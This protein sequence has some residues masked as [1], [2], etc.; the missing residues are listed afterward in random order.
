MAAYGEKRKVVYFNLDQPVQRQLWDFAGNI[1][2]GKE[3]K[4]FLGMRMRGFTLEQ[5]IS[6]TAHHDTLRI[7]TSMFDDREKPV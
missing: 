7:D 2:F 5:M 3:V 6:N 4:Q 1:E